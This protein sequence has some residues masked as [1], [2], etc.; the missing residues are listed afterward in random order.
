MKRFSASSKLYRHQNIP[1]RRTY[2]FEGPPGTGKSSLVQAL[3]TYFRMHICTIN[4]SDPSLT[5]ANLSSMMNTIPQNSVILIEDVDALASMSRY[6]RNG[7]S[8]HSILNCLDGVTSQE[9]TSKE[10]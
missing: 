8:W 2:L 3:V 5:E 6:I 7:L 1:Y 9:G 10:M 4:L